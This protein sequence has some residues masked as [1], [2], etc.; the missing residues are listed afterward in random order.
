[1][2]TNLQKAKRLLQAHSNISGFELPEDGFIFRML[3]LAA[4]PNIEQ[5]KVELWWSGLSYTEK[6]GSKI[7]TFGSGNDCPDGCLEYP[8]IEKMYINTLNQK[9]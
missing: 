1:M 9:P 3:E 8:D 6:E 4:S 7:K 5:K 2:E